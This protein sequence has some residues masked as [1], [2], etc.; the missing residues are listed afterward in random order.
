[1]KITPFN[2]S[3]KTFINTQNTENGEVDTQT[4]FYYSQQGDVIEADYRGGVVLT[5]HL[6]GRMTAPDRFHMVYHHLNLNGELRVGQCEST[7]CIA[8][9]GK[10]ILQESWQW[11]NGDLSTGHSQLVEING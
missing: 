4:I 6:M 10:L 7:I 2:L 11:L 9:D 8:P 5:G 3:G 1:M